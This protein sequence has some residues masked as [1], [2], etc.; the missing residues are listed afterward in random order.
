MAARLI[1]TPAA[2]RAARRLVAD[3]FG[4]LLGEETLDDVQLVVSELVTNAVR[5]GRGD[6]DLRMTFDGRL[7]TGAV[8]DKGRGFKRRPR[9]HDPAR[10]GGHGLYIVGRVSEAWGTDDGHTNVW[11]QILARR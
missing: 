4:G 2:V 5:Y 1:R 9:E 10:V 8:S 11:F 3:H 7:L 6:V